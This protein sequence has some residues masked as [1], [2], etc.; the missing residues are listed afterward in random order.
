MGVS[1][2]GGAGGGRRRRGQRALPRM[3]EINMTPFIDVMLV[4]LIIFMVAA[5]LLASG[6]PIDLPQTKAAAL[7]IDQ[8]PISVSI[9]DK[10][11]VTV[12][13]RPSSEAARRQA[14]G[15]AKAGADERIYVR[16]STQ[17]N[18][19]KIAEVMSIITSS[20]F[21]RVALVTEPAKILARE[22]A[23]WRRTI[24]ASSAPARCTCAVLGAAARQLL[25]APKFEDAA[26]ERAGRDDHGRP[27]STRSRRARRRPP[28]PVPQRRAD[29]RR[30]RS[31]SPSPSRRR[32]GEEGRAAA[33][34]RRA[35][36]RTTRARTTSRCRRRR[37]ASPPAPAP[38]P[39]RAATEPHARGQ[40]EPT[41][42]QRPSRRS[43]A[44]DKPAADKPA[45]TAAAGRR[46]G[47]SPSPCRAPRSSRR[48][49]RGEAGRSPPTPASP[50]RKQ[51]VKEPSEPRTAGAAK[52]PEPASSPTSSPSC[53]RTRRT[54]SRRHGR[55]AA[56][57]PRSRRAHFDSP[58]I[59][60]L[61]VHEAPQRKAATGAEADAGRLA[62]RAQ[63]QRRGAVAL[64]D[65]R[66]SPT[67]FT[68]STS[69]AGPISAW[70]RRQNYVPAVRLHLLQD[71]TLVG[72]P[73]LDQSAVRPQPAQPRRQRGARGAEVQ[74]AE[75][76]RAV[77]ALLRPVARPDHPLRPEGAA[78]TPAGT[79]GAAGAV[80]PDPE[81][82]HDV[83]PTRRSGGCSSPAPPPR[84]SL[85][86]RS[87]A[88]SPR[89]S[90]STC[91]AA[92]R[93]S[94]IP[95]AVTTFGGDSGGQVASVITNNFKRSVFITPVERAP[96]PGRARIRPRRWTP[97]A[98]S[99]RNTWSPAAS[100]R[101]GG[102]RADGVPAVG[103]RHGRAGH[104]P[105]ICDGRQ[106]PA[107]R[108]AYRLGRR[109]HQGHGREG[110]L[111]HARRVHRRVRAGGAPPQAPRH[112]GP[113]RRGRA[114]S[115]PRRRSG[116]DAALLADVAGHHLHGVRRLR[117]ARAVHEHRD[118]AE[119]DGG[120]VFPA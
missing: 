69:A 118:G 112:H 115:H 102:R 31:P 51:P 45:R 54:R 62:R 19:G 68:T 72:Q 66:S 77:R 95:I 11:C 47:A 85:P 44:P 29:K 67:I 86:R 106:Q 6:V 24:P 49:R 81:D 18:Y 33:A 8:K 75:D 117:A 56:A 80:R 90:R 22:W 58:N 98:R 87:A 25:A 59:S 20:G 79:T 40:A 101:S 107:P 17:V 103:R 114:L 108:R 38:V 1:A 97:T 82:L 116:G 76:P 43:R 37:S 16:G 70:L 60:A 96:T 5:P 99:T 111:R 55:R 9:D 3:A 7:N 15:V 41:P 113:G 105:A 26:G 61:L 36:R 39:A 13:D 84:R 12:N 100:N 48:R 28:L 83:S 2:A 65:G 57:T 4:L 21:K 32:R 110:L 91:G 10:G 35:S 119:A 27:N 93:S 92:R 50:P 46:G 63:R 109:V 73:Q 34:R 52:K 71:G 120:Q 53:W 23:R 104:R 30:R 42:P 64:H 14:E 88:P 89:A 78:V 94:P 74:P